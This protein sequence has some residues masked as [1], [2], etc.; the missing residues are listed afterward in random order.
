MN[1]LDNQEIHGEKLNELDYSRAESYKINRRGS[2]FQ[3]NNAFDASLRESPIKRYDVDA[4]LDRDS[5][6][7]SF[8]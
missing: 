1:S 8:I 7:N 4:T 3:D 2:N 6:M 5:R